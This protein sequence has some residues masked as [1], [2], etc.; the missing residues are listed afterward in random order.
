MS[1]NYKLTIMKE[2]SI[3]G[4]AK[5]YDELKVKAS[6]IYNKEN[7]VLIMHTIEDLFPEFRESED[8]RMKEAI[9]A[10]IHLYYGEPLEN[11]AKEM[12]AWLEKQGEQKQ[13]WGKEDQDNFKHLMDEI[14]C[15]GNSRNSANRLYYDSLIKFLD[16]LKDR[17]QPREKW[18][19]KDERKLYRLIAFFEKRLAFTDNDYPEYASWLKSL[20]PQNTWKPS[21]EQMDAFEQVYDW[22]NNNFAPSE[23]LTSLYNDLKKLK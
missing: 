9:I 22:Y 15:L 6:R 17:A 14:V 23:T 2:L 10:T 19:D 4:K 5:A 11:E 18:C 13:G 21:D 8:E 12:I 20:R 16:E 3:E 1:E 7:D